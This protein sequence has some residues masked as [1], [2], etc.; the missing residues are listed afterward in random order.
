[1]T[2]PRGSLFKS[3]ICLPY[4]MERQCD[5]EIHPGT[6]PQEA[7][8]RDGSRFCLSGGPLLAGM[9]AFDTLS[10]SYDAAFE[11]RPPWPFYHYF[12]IAKLLLII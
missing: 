10:R 1:M 8:H 11:K 6:A 4:F 7:L 2:G 3:R 12:L 5:L 9:G